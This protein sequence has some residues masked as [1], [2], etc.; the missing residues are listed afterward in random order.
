MDDENEINIF[1]DQEK[2]IY[3]PIS[4]ELKCI[5]FH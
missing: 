3:E 4:E 2:I 5:T 1:K